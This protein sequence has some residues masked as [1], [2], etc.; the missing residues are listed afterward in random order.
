MNSPYRTAPSSQCTVRVDCCGEKHR[1]VLY[2][3]GKAKCLDHGDQFAAL[4][5]ITGE[6]E[7]RGCLRVREA[8][9]QRCQGRVMTVPPEVEAMCVEISARRAMAK[10]RAF[11]FRTKDRVLLQWKKSS[12]SKGT[13]RAIADIDRLAGG[14]FQCCAQAVST[15]R[16]LAKENGAVG[17]CRTWRIPP[18]CTPSTRH[19]AVAAAD[20]LG[21]VRVVHGYGRFGQGDRFI[22]TDFGGL[23]HSLYT[24]I[25]F[26][27]EVEQHHDQKLWAAVHVAEALAGEEGQHL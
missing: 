25:V 26:G 13:L 27:V 5:A 20:K 18:G 17:C 4:S 6:P 11:R 9:V 16:A 7:D 22:G 14:A 19:I 15:A 3:S 21:G 8:L 23:I 12:T 2:R 24:S 1:V 10:S